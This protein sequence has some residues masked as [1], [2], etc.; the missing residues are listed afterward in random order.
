MSDTESDFPSTA[1]ATTTATTTAK[2]T[3]T[4][5]K[6]KDDAAAPKA[7]AAP[8]NK[9]SELLT[10]QSITD[11]FRQSTTTKTVRERDAITGDFVSRQ[12][13]TAPCVSSDVYAPLDATLI[14][15]IKMYAPQLAKYR[16]RPA[17]KAFVQLRRTS[18]DAM[19]SEL[20]IEFTPTQRRRIMFNL[21][22]FASVAV[23]NSIDHL[24]SAIT[25]YSRNV[26]PYLD[27]IEVTVLAPMRL[28]ERDADDEDSLFELVAP[29]R[30]RKASGGDDGD[31]GDADADE[32][33]ADDEEAEAE[34]PPPPPPAKK[35]K[36]K[37]APQPAPSSPKKA[38]A[39]PKP[40]EPKEPKEAKAPTKPKSKA[41]TEADAAE[42]PQATRAAP[43]PPKAPQAT[44]ATK[45]T[46]AAKAPQATKSS[47]KSASTAKASTPKKYGD[48]FEDLGDDDFT[49]AATTTAT[50]DD[51]EGYDE[52][53][54]ESG[55]AYDD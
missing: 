2:K 26:Q 18:V 38:K 34:A 48:A 5:A 10:L 40:K 53:G 33:A 24:H 45:A 13:E 39:P 1:A 7:K 27:T 52:S 30:K 17:N 4:K 55:E 47:T 20:A 29:K 50:P 12:E 22:C 36:T 41:V 21:S 28:G 9:T 23:E 49:S 8:R 42:P 16:Y 25:V 46:K 43:R 32:A 6:A 44:K 51:D 35:T 14:R 54:G 31:D 11:F 3:K 15:W 37:A 19:I